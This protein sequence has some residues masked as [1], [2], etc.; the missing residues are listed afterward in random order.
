MDTFFCLFSEV[1]ID[2]AH[3]HATCDASSLQEC[4]LIFCSA[5]VTYK[6][7]S[8][9][10]NP[11]QHQTTLPPCALALTLS[12]SLVCAKCFN[13]V[14]FVFLAS[15]ATLF[16][17][18]ICVLTVCLLFSLPLSSSMCFNLSAVIIPPILATCVVPHSCL[19]EE[20]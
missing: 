12:L 13:C 9:A 19:L 1:L 3:A 17:H 20:I 7:C 14:V 5:S 15:Y 11:W 18:F 16:S 2:M 10:L 6:Y 4:A 8:G